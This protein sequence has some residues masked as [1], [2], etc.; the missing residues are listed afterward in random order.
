MASETFWCWNPDDGDEEDAS[1]YDVYDAESAATEHAKTRDREGGDG[2]SEE[3]T[4]VVGCPDGERLKFTVTAEPSV[5]YRARL[6]D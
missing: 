2:Y 3:Q 1:E 4:I 6:E 5:T